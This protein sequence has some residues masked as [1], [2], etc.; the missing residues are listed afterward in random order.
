MKVTI[1]RNGL[2]AALDKIVLLTLPALL[3][4][5]PAFLFAS[6]QIGTTGRSRY[7]DDLVQLILGTGI[8]AGAIAAAYFVILAP[9][10]F[11]SERKE[12]PLPFGATTWAESVSA[13]ERKAQLRLMNIR[14]FGLGGVGTLLFIVLLPLIASRPGELGMIMIIPVII[15]FI[16]FEMIRRV[17]AYDIADRRLRRADRRTK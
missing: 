8:L 13:E 7:P 17:M 9:L 5:I 15:F 6:T 10:W 1:T 14:A 3:L 11:F 12:A 16:S 2:R 4:S